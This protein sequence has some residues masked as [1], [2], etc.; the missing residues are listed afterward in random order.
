MENI[1]LLYIC[2]PF[3]SFGW[4]VSEGAAKT[5]EQSIEFPIFVTRWTLKA[6]LRII[7]W[8]DYVQIIELQ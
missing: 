6:I 7:W 2:H 5:Q 4:K 1:L 3:E 8:P